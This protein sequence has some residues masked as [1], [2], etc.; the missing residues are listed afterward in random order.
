MIHR[1]LCHFWSLSTLSV[2]TSL[3]QCNKDIHKLSLLGRV[4]EARQMF[5]TMPRRDSGSWNTMISGYIQNGLLNKAQELF[6]SF[7]G[8][9]VRTWTI[10][11]SGYARHGRAH[12]AKA[13]FESMPERNVVSW[14]AM[15][16]AYAQNGLLRSARDVFDQMPE[17]NTVSWNSMIT[18]YCHC[19]M[20]GEARELFDQME[21][22]N[23]ASWM[24]MVSGYV[25]IGECCDAWMV[26]L[27]MLR[28]SVRPDQA[29]LVTALLAVMR[30]N[31]LELIES[32]RVMALKTGYESNVVVGTA[33]LNAYIANGSLEY[34]VKLFERMPERN[35]YSWSTM[36]AAFSQGGRLDDAIALY[37]RDTGKGVGTQT[38]MVTA[39]AQ[40]GRIHEARHIFHE[41]ANPTVVTWNAMVTGYAQN[42]MLEEAKDIFYKTPVPNAASWAAMISGFIQNGQSREALEVFAE[43]HSSGI[44]P[45]HSNFTSALFA[46]ANIED[47]EMGRQIHCFVIKTRNHF[48]SFVGNGLIS[49][50]AKCKSTDVSQACRIKGVGDSVSWLSESHTLDDARKT[51]EQ[52]PRRDV[53]SWSA[54][55][56]A[57]E[58]AGQADTAFKLFFEMLW[59]GLKPNESTI[60]SLLSACGYLGATKL[61]EQIHALIHKLGLDT[62]L[63]VCN[64][65]IT[66]YFKC[67][68]L[69]GLG[70]FR[71]MPDRDIVTWNAVLT[72]CA[73]NGLGKEAVEVFKQMETTG[74]SPNETSFLAL[75]CACSHAGLVDEG[76]T[77][78]NSMSQHYGIT[79]SVYHYTCMVDLL[80]RAGWL[81]EAED[82]IKSMPV[83]PDSVIWEALLGAC[84]IHRN[85][86]L[87]QRVAERLFQMGTK[88]S[89]T[90]VLL[91]NMYASRGMWGKVREIREMMSDRGVTKEP[92]ISWIQIKNK[93][94]Y[95]LMGEKA[96]DEIKE[97]NMAVNELY[98]RFRATGYVPDT[99][100]VLHDVAE[101]QK[102]DDLLFHSEKLAVAYGIL[103]TPNGAPIQILKNL[104]ICGDC[105]SFMKFVSSVA[106]RKIILR[107]GNRFH[108]F[109]DGLCSCGDYW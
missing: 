76:W 34:G 17:R 81:S 6:D 93:V 77:Y 61:G 29:I 91:S 12:E 100:F 15:I 23:I 48:N 73:Q 43:L 54:I 27:M 69:D 63:F 74:I 22:R 72:G 4:T 78:F 87:G 89:G 50:Y 102:E 101:E 2:P 92:G 28:S 18:G 16:T 45:N 86:E 10:L 19:G 58:Q 107:D 53:V 33:F 71:E 66:M 64:A 97:I 40:N 38:A 14:N 52:M 94:H 37:E 108:H 65:L 31:K 20:M 96:H 104:R 98:R 42:G 68:I 41:I 1:R 32:L 30:F 105:H 95:F 56:S 7:Q 57:Y 26:F 8:K 25:E 70:I 67:G 47:V 84:R 51:F 83:K 5:D 103:Q 9:N 44:V 82:L 59:R 80:G 99:N 60:T 46:C 13:V 88:R 55:I 106:Q 85:T 24:V 49:M 11:L 79:P 62:C 39:Y 75:L 21:E 90:Y 109:Q 3:L 35:E 36:I